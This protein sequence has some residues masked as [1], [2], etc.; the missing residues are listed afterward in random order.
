MDIEQFLSVFGKY[1]F[2]AKVCERGILYANVIKPEMGLY[3]EIDNSM[4]LSLTATNGMIFRQ[5]LIMWQKIEDA[6]DAE[7]LLRRNHL[8]YE[9]CCEKLDLAVS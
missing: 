4:D 3:I 6:V 2:E 7:R 9:Q 5:T 1:G 8:F